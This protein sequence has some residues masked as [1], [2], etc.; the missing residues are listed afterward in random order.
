MVYV[1]GNE[2]LPVKRMGKIKMSQTLVPFA[3]WMDAIPRR[4]TCVI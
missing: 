2:F 4:A 3:A 1:E